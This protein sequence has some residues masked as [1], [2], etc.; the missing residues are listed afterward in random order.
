MSYKEPDF[1]K[2]V[3]TYRLVLHLSYFKM[4][5]VDSIEMKEPITYNCSIVVVV[6]YNQTPIRSTR[7][8][9]FPFFFK[10][11]TDTTVSVHWKVKPIGSGFIVIS[12]KPGFSLLYRST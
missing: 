11:R 5:H 12:L 9:F 8:F 10:I 4:F 3:T 2:A 6:V 7:M 1:L